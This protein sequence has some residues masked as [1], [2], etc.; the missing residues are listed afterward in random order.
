M[1]YLFWE[2]DKKKGWL[3]QKY[4]DGTPCNGGPYVFTILAIE[5]LIAIF[6]IFGWIL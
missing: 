6:I 4:Q 1:K 2:W 5:C 3:D